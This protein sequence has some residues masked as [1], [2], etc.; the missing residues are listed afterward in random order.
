MICHAKSKGF[1]APNLSGSRPHGPLV[2]AS[3]RQVIEVVEGGNAEKAGVRAGD[4]LRAT[5]AMA[6]N[7][8][9]SMDTV[10]NDHRRGGDAR[11]FR[12]L[13]QRLGR[14]ARG[15]HDSGG[16]GRS[17]GA[18]CVS[19]LPPRASS[20]G[21]SALLPPRRPVGRAPIATARRPAHRGRR[22]PGQGR[23][24][25][26]ALHG[27]RPILRRAHGRTNQ[28]LGR[29]EGPGGRDVSWSSV[30]A[31]PP[32]RGVCVRAR[33]CGASP[34]PPAALSSPIDLRLSDGARTRA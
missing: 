6:V 20:V 9:A 26:R 2:D 25:A 28:Q 10:R 34:P 31:P 19:A 32:R 23:P 12:L 33:V 4:V 14:G 5:T 21:R 18:A 7:A 11:E 17:N 29:A 15:D 27:R 16:L 13:A 22:V 30:R 1:S 24:A 8:K 3:M